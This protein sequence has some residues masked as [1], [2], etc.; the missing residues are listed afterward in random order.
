MGAPSAPSTEIWRASRRTLG[1]GRHPRVQR[2][3][4]MDRCTQAESRGR[5][6]ECPDSRSSLQFVGSLGALLVFLSISDLLPFCRYRER[7]IGNLFKPFFNSVRAIVRT[8]GMWERDAAV[9]WR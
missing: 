7:E 1:F 4:T 9:P 6:T 3:N 5:G 2:L 8:A